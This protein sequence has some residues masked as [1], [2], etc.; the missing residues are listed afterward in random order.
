[1]ACRTLLFLFALAFTQVR[2]LQV[3]LKSNSPYCFSFQAD[4]QTVL[5][6]DYLITGINP[7]LVNFEASQGKKILKS[8]KEARSNELKIESSSTEQIS[9]CW[10]KSDNKAKK[11]DFSVKRNLAHSLDDADAS[12]LDSLKADLQVLMEEL[13]TISRNI[14]KQKSIE[15]EHF[16][17]ASS[18]SSTQTWMSILKMLIV[19]GICVG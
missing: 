8:I 18:A 14:E 5:T 4:L 13:E 7:E 16:G 1:M 10:F 19:I 11:L 9:M 2:A 12:T 17:L 15:N 6:V 3:M